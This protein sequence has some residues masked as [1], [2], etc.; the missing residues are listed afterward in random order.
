MMMGTE[1]G[2][3]ISGLKGALALVKGV[4]AVSEG[5]AVQDVQIELGQRIIEAQAALNAAMAAQTEAAERICELEQEIVHLKDWSAE[6]ERYHLVNAD[7]GA[8][9]YMPKPGMENG[10]PAHWLCTNCFNQGRKSFMLFKGQDVS[11][12]G[13]RGNESTYGCDSC[14]SN[15]KV[16]YRAKPAYPDGPE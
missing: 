13:S 8:F 3:A 4:K 12:A 7:R 2:G 16:F 11:R 1:I 6:R 10:E 14:G 9:V 5:L 15:L